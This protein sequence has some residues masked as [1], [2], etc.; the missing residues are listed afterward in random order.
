LH[1]GGTG[2]DAPVIT[3]IGMVGAGSDAG[4]DVE[5]STARDGVTDGGTVRP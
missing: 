3:R 2:Q 5:S 1:P 4:R